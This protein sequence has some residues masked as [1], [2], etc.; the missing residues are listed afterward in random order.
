MSTG[1]EEDIVRDGRVDKTGCK[2]K[3]VAAEENGVMIQDQMTDVTRSA[4]YVASECKESAI[5]DQHRVYGYSADSPGHV[6]GAPELVRDISHFA[7]RREEITVVCRRS[8]IYKCAGGI[9]EH[10]VVQLHFVAVTV[11]LDKRSGGLDRVVQLS[12][13]VK[14]LSVIESTPLAEMKFPGA[15]LF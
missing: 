5:L 9:I 6:A 3:I 13:E 1:S 7:A 4:E 8:E 15:V 14:L 10:D 11:D 12:E 2:D